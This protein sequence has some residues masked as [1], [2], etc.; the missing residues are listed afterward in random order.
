MIISEIEK[1]NIKKFFPFF[2]K[3]YSISMI[4]SIYTFEEQYLWVTNR[5]Y[6]VI[7]H[8]CCGI[9]I[10][11]HVKFLLIDIFVAFYIKESFQEVTIFLNNETLNETTVEN[12][13]KRITVEEVIIKVNIANKNSLDVMKSTLVWVISPYHDDFYFKT[14]EEDRVKKLCKSDF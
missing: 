11:S 13:I 9:I 12:A 2:T 5:E 14:K 1:A 6:V 3:N 10:K 4:E 8:E 7:K